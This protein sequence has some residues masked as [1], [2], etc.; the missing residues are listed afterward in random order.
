[1]EEKKSQAAQLSVSIT[2]LP[3]KCTLEQISNFCKKVGVLATH[4]ETGEDLILHN[5][6]SNRATVTYSYPEG[7]NQA[8][9]ILD[10]E[11]FSEGYQVSVERAAH[12]P[13]DFS[14]WKK[15]MRMTRK[16]HSYIIGDEELKKDEIK[17]NKIMILKNVFTTKEMVEDPDLYGKIVK[18]LTQTCEKYGKVSLVKPMEFNAEGTVIVR[19]DD[20][21]SAA[22]AIGELDSAKY[23][24]REITSEM[25]DGKE[26]ESKESQESVNERIERYQKFLENKE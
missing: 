3:P 2:K 14:K 23:R 19:F 8:I 6:K 18:E 7:V 13:F 11:I 12:E 24:D 25:W 22:L 16:F 17:R 10:G 5:E 26:I 15:A 9:K 1:M 20:P 4:P 21:Q